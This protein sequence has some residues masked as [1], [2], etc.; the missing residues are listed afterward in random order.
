MGAAALDTLT[1]LLA[2]QA[3]EAAAAA[4]GGTVQRRGGKPLPTKLLA[5]E[6]TREQFEALQAQDCHYC[7]KANSASHRNGVDRKDN[8]V[9]YTADNS[10]CCC[11]VC[12]LVKADM[13][14]A[15]LIEQCK[16]IAEFGAT[17]AVIQAYG[18]APRVN[19]PMGK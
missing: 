15:Q 8:A 17:V 14:D 11:M 5:F 13:T 2:E 4:T 10:V 16:R 12:N 6:L 1:R 7:G 3:A 19:H 18:D 9:G